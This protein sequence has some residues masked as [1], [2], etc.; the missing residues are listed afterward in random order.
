MPKVIKD[1]KLNGESSPFRGNC[2]NVV[3]AHTVFAPRPQLRGDAYFLD[4]FPSLRVKCSC[5]G[6]IGLGRAHVGDQS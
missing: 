6:I 3:G 1:S 4:I 5:G 2:G